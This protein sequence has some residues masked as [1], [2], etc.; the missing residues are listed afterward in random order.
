[1][2][3]CESVPKRLLVRFNQLFFRTHPVGP[4]HLT[5]THRQTDCATPDSTHLVCTACSADDA[6]SWN[7][8]DGRRLCKT[9]IDSRS[10]GSR[11][12]VRNV[13][14]WHDMTLSS[15][16]R[17]LSSEVTQGEWRRVKLHE[18]FIVCMT[19]EWLTSERLRLYTSNN[20]IL[21][22]LSRHVRDRFIAFAIVGMAYIGPNSVHCSL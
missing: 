5:I 4:Y 6:G 13:V 20:V 22:S 10:D 12:P 7:A 21:Y 2:G 3:S 15:G 9:N 14:R 1:M 19:D 17:W 18:Q 11:E 8:N 16:R